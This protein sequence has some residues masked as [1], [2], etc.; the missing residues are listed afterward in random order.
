MVYKRFV[1]FIY[2]YFRYPFW[3]H[4]NFQKKNNCRLENDAIFVGINLSGHQS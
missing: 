3:G 4:T 2:A 1:Q